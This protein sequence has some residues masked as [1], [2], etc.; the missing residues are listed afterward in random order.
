MV[1]TMEFVV[2]YML[3]IRIQSLLQRVKQEELESP[4]D[5]QRPS[6]SRTSALPSQF[7]GSLRQIPGYTRASCNCDDLPKVTV[8]SVLFKVEVLELQM[9]IS[10]KSKPLWALWLL[11]FQQ[12]AGGFLQT[13]NKKG[14]A[15]RTHG[16][17]SVLPQL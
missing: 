7:R 5:V 1:Y 15:L 12:K 8:C 14:I 10:L 13:G 4:P 9:S 2:E 6:I 3:P 11:W 16:S 17:F